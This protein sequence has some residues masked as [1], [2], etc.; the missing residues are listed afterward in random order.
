MPDAI[1]ID[2]FQNQRFSPILREWGQE[3]PPYGHLLPTDR[4]AYTSRNG[5]AVLHKLRPEKPSPTRE[6]TATSTDPDPL[7][8]ADTDHS[9][10]LGTSTGPD[11][12]PVHDPG[13]DPGLGAASGQGMENVDTKPLLLDREGFSW[14]GA[15]MRQMLICS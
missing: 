8:L 7:S 13:P 12:V 9:L 3:S 14:V 2:V 4:S 15:V 6:A 11:L 1:R 10:G 5:E